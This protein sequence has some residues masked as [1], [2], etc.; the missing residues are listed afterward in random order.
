MRVMVQVYMV[1][2]DFV[3]A[4]VYRWYDITEYEGAES[5]TL[6]IS[7]TR[8]CRSPLNVMVTL[9]HHRLDLYDRRT[10]ADSVIAD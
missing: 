4:F 5:M 8:R 7:D 6:P 3:D 2:E 9:L 10:F 1:R